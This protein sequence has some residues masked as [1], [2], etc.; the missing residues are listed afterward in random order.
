MEKRRGLYNTPRY[1]SNSSIVHT[2]EPLD[3]YTP[4]HIQTTYN[5]DRKALKLSQKVDARLT[6]FVN[7]KKKKYIDRD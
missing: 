6:K 2:I 4:K 3:P 1:I 7:L 5:Q